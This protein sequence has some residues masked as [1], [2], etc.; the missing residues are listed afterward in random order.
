MMRFVAIIVLLSLLSIS[1]AFMTRMPA[2]H[3]IRLSPRLASTPAPEAPAPE[4]PIGDAADV[5][6][7]ESGEAV[8]EDPYANET[9]EERY[10]RTKLAEIAERKAAEVFITQNT[11]RFECQA[12]GYMYLE[13]K[14]YEKKGIAAGTPFEE[15]EKF[16]CPQC[17]ANKKYFKAETEI[18][19]GFK[20]NQNYGLGTNKM[21]EGQKSN[22][23]Y[24]GLFLGFIFFMSGYL[25]E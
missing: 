15:I 21:T 19:S 12:C 22:L 2:R 7:A 16:R 10:K 14:G 5:T 23:I 1:T 4:I 11:G 6:G 8:E 24:G 13:S 25:L 3:V 20:E 18:I 9:E 17:G